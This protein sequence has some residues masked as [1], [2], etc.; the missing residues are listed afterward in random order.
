[1]KQVVQPASGGPVRVVDVPAPVIGPTG[2]LVQTLTSIISPGTERAVTELA[3]SSIL[4]KARA[5]PD[6]VRQVLR[7]ART[8]GPSATLR[9]VRGQLDRLVPL[10][11][12]ASGIVLEVG[13]AVAGIAPGALV[14]TSGA[15]VANHA[16]LQAIPGLLCTPVPAGV[17]HEAAAFTTLGAIALHGLRVGGLDP[18]SSIV[19][20]GLGLV[21]QLAVRLAFASGCRVAALDLDAYRVGVAV[22]GGALGIIEDGAAATA[23]VLDWSRGRGADAVIVAAADP[24]GAALRRAPELC[25]DRAAVVVLGD[26]AVSVSRKPFYDKEL[27]LRFSRSYGPGR[28]ERSYEDWAVDYP[29]GDV[30]W[31]EG[32]NFEAVLDLLAG[33]RLAVDD[34]V[35]H[36]FPVEQAEAAY[37]VVQRSDEHSLAIA[38]TYPQPAALPQVAPAGKPRAP[39]PTGEPGVGLIGAGAF[40]TS[41]LLPALKDAGFSRLTAVASASGLS[42]LQVAER[43]G[44]AESVS[45]ALAVI[46]HPEVDVVVV[47]G[48]HDTHAAH[49]CRALRAGK[50]VFCEKP[51]ALSEDEL[52][53]VEDAAASSDGVLF[54]GFNRRWSPALAEVRR[55]FSP[56]A[57]PLVVT[58]R[59]NAGPVPAGHWYS[60]R[61]QGGRLLGE[62]CHFVDTCSAI[63]GAH[64][65]HVHAAGSSHAETLLADDY[66][67]LLRYGDG[68]LATVTY[69]AG[70]HGGTEKER[71]EVLGRGR[72]AVISDFREVVLDGRSSGSGRQDKGHRAEL[73][74]F[75]QAVRSG[76]RHH[77]ADAIA[78]GRATLA[79]AASLGRTG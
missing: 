27:S 1:M 63:V 37:D 35:T 77:A 52:D 66:A 71:V 18:G 51:I 58:Y 46:E 8:D 78:T 48:P 40:A 75:R 33:G 76:E 59:V 5:R 26:M 73:A 60:D 14:A 15:G 65:A 2:V 43:H 24:T 79:A 55:H 20:I 3:Q 13:E 49:V 72:S 11:Y 70:G 4:D 36:R 57:G 25:R 45:G 42:A 69:A 56:G 44:F 12:S 7:K 21:G 64:P 32:R 54:V 23:N 19:V 41:V 16:E 50:H 30:R 61:R 29:V 22:N 17:G 10:G 31:T 38:F 53:D 28:Y 67:V 6:L 62:V 39:R 47:A 9:A 34:L 68:S 74:A